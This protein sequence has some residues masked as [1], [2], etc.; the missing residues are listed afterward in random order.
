[1]QAQE[2]GGQLAVDVHKF[3]RLSWADQWDLVPCTGQGNNMKGMAAGKPMLV[4][5]YIKYCAYFT[6]SCM[7]HTECNSILYG[8]TSDKL[9]Y[10]CFGFFFFKND[11]AANHLTRN[12][13]K[14]VPSS[15]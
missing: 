5:W 1:M 11:M 3:G 10:L 8:M 13:I 6:I 9:F 4:N 12:N 15:L 14:R 7:S 2:V